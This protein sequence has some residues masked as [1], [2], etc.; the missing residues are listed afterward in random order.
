MK[1]LEA[2]WTFRNTASEAFAFA[3]DFGRRIE[4][5]WSAGARL[6]ELLQAAAIPAHAR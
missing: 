5:W 6:V 4:G 3:S 2:R 1:G